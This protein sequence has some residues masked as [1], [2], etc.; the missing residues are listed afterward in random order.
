MPANDPKAESAA[1]PVTAQGLALITKAIV[2][3]SQHPGQCAFEG[4]PRK[5]RM[6]NDEKE[7]KR[8]QQAAP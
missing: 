5:I 2:T 1:S 4:T 7:T 8:A 6:T 3:K